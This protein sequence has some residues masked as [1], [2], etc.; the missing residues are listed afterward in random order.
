MTR[1][2][3]RVCPHPECHRRIPQP[4]F[5]CKAHWY[6]L[7]P[8]DRDQIDEAWTDFQRH[9]GAVTLRNLRRAE[10]HALEVWRHTPPRPQKHDLIRQERTGITHI[11]HGVVTRRGGRRIAAARCGAIIAG[12]PTQ[13]TIHA[14]TCP[15]C[16]PTIPT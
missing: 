2:A 14:V 10:S 15:T 4:S 8:A 7:P 5:A 16:R 1:T 6:E 12:Q 9:P 3:V 13:D 11:I